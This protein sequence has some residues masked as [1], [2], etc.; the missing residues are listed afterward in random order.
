MDKYITEKELRSRLNLSRAT[1]YRYKTT[2]G[3]PFIKI[4]GKTFYDL[5]EIKVFFSK[6][7][8]H[9]KKNIDESK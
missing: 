5:D 4:G 2:L 1:I 7:S 6:H 9:I 8:S 3:L